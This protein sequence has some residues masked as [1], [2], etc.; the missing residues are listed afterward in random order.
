MTTKTMDWKLLG[1]SSLAIAFGLFV[2]VSSL[3]MPATQ[4][5][6]QISSALFPSIVGGAML[7][8]GLVMAVQ[9]IRGGWACELSRLCADG[10]AKGALLWI[11]AGYAAAIAVLVFAGS[12]VIAGTALYLLAFMAFGGANWL[13]PLLA[14]F[15][16][17]CISYIVFAILLDM[18]FGS[19]V[20]ERGLQWAIPF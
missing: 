14:G 17:S 8:C 4:L 11:L 12:F 5:Y 9:S 1:A 19:G 3:M 2:L 13:R 10:F 18:Q 6:S 7:V 20:I 15:L 16:L